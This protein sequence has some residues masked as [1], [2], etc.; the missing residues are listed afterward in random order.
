MKAAMKVFDSAA[1]GDEKFRIRVE[2]GDGV[3][4]TSKVM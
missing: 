4:K 3:S 1:V 2:F